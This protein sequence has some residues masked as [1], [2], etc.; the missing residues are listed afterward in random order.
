ML[1]DFS[2]NFFHEDLL[3]DRPCEEIAAEIGAWTKRKEDSPTSVTHSPLR[4]LGTSLD[5]DTVNFLTQL[6][7][8]Y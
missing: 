5:K 1:C 3:D 4:V 6:N 7:F 2:D 8:E